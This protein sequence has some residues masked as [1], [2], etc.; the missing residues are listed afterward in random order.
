MVC[1]TRRQAGGPG[2]LAA[3]AKQRESEADADEA[4]KRFGNAKSIS[5]AQFNSAEDSGAVDYEKQVGPKST[6]LGMH[7]MQMQDFNN[8]II[9][10]SPSQGMELR[11][12]CYMCEAC[13][14]SLQ[15]WALESSSLF[16]ARTGAPEPLPGR[17]RHLQRRLL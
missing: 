2:S 8:T 9:L 14:W 5:S 1:C 7:R 17:E 4:R 3:L 16:A 10:H 11:V 15:C 13:A 6:H 12:G